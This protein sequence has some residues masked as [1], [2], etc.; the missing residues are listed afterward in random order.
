MNFIYTTND[1]KLRHISRFNVFVA[2]NLRLN[3]VQPLNTSS[4]TYTTHI[5]YESSQRLWLVEM[6]SVLKFAK[7]ST[8]IHGSLSRDGC[9]LVSWSLTSTTLVSLQRAMNYPKNVVVERRSSHCRHGRTYD[10]YRPTNTH[11]TSSELRFVDELVLTVQRR[12]FTS[13]RSLYV[14]VTA[15][16]ER[17]YQHIERTTTLKR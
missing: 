13:A 16:A 5:S 15:T 1:F 8:T 2:N 9:S 11:T 17:C 10:F 7:T 4:T 12:S 3:A 6:A 14:L